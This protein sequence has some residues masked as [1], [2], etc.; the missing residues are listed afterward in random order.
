MNR[1]KHHLKKTHHDDD[2]EVLFEQLDVDTKC[3][4]FTKY[5]E[6][7]NSLWGDFNLFDNIHNVFKWIRAGK[8]ISNDCIIALTKYDLIN[9]NF[10]IN[11]ILKVINDNI[12]TEI[13]E[14]LIRTKVKLMLEKYYLTPNV[15][16][17]FE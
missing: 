15:K 11:A 8:K 7:S 6:E 12:P 13:I 17:T 14:Q 2:A 5:Y 1:L 16:L 4:Y 3:K 10:H 9:T